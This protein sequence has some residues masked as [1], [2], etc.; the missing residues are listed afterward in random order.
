MVGSS[1]R[2]ERGGWRRGA[3]LLPRKAAVPEGATNAK[4]EG[5][6]G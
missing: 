3:L 2:W 4:F 5:N 1:K 6:V